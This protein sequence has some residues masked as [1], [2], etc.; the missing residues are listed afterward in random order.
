MSSL[1]EIQAQWEPVLKLPLRDIFDVKRANDPTHVIK[2]LR[3]CLNLTDDFRN[4][5]NLINSQALSIERVDVIGW[6]TEILDPIRDC[7]M[8]YIGNILYNLA[9]D[10]Y[11]S[12][13]AEQIKAILL[14]FAQRDKAPDQYGCPHIG[15]LFRACLDSF[16]TVPGSSAAPE[17]ITAERFI[18]NMLHEDA[19]LW[20]RFREYA[21]QSYSMSQQ[22]HRSIIEEERTPSA[23]QTSSIPLNNSQEL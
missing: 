7:A 17:R 22:T 18:L 11:P 13:Q 3:G 1:A 5:D 16:P 10:R 9:Q 19:D 20:S 12:T 6:Q 2:S 14:E 8:Q 15:V 4:V 23:P 21:P